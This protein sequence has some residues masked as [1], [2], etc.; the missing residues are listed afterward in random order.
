[1]R[2]DSL[3][4]DVFSAYLMQ[5]P[6]RKIFGF[7]PYVEIYYFGKQ[8]FRPEKVDR[9]I[10]HTQRRYQRRIERHS[11]ND[12]IVNRL[13]EKRERRLSV[14]QTKRQ[15][16]NFWM[17]VVGEQPAIFDR[18]KANESIINIR[19]YLYT[20][21]FFDANVRLRI[22]TISQKGRLLRASYI[23]KEGS[24]YR[25]YDYK[26]ITAQADIDSLLTPQ[27]SRWLPSGSVYDREQLESIRL[28]IEKSLRDSGY[29]RFSR[30]YV[31]V[32][33][34]TNQQKKTAEL[35]FLINEP[36]RIDTSQFNPKTIGKEATSMA[37]LDNIY[38]KHIRYQ[39]AMP[40]F[41]VLEEGK[42][43]DTSLA[44]KSPTYD[45]DTIRIYTAQQRYKP[46]LLSENIHLRRQQWFSESGLRQTQQSLISLDMFKFIN[47]SLED[48]RNGY[49]IPVI[50]VNPIE[51]LSF[52]AEGGLSVVQGLPGPFIS[53]SLK[54]RNPFGGLEIFENSFRFAIDGQTSLS[55][56]RQVFSSTE[57]NFSSSLVIPHFL[58][59]R[60]WQYRFVKRQPKTTFGINFNFINRPEYTRRNI[61][62]FL[63]Y[64]W[65]TI[66]HYRYEVTPIDVNI[67]N[68]DRTP[69]LDDFLERLSSPL[70][71][72][73]F[74]NAFIIS[75]QGSWTYNDI[76]QQNKISRY[77]RFY[78]ESGG[79]VLNLF[80]RAFF[81]DENTF[82]GL[83]YFKYLKFYT[84]LR[85][86]YPLG[87]HNT[88]A[89]R[90]LGGAVW[91]YGTSNTVPYEK[92]F[93]AGG[94]NSL[95]AW[96]PR[97]L[98]PGSYDHIDENGM[99]SYRFEQPGNI[100]LEGSVEYRFK[101]WWIIN[102]ALFV[103]MGN[104]WTLTEDPDRPGAKISTNFWREIAFGTGFGLRFDFTFLLLRLDLGIKAID[105]AMP[106]GQ[107]WVLHNLSLR[108]P[109]SGNNP[110]M[111]NI[112]I[113]Y[114]F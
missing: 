47:I 89:M 71:Q 41:L 27:L 80:D 17:R 21:G 50:V 35:H 60:R 9:Q 44:Y 22:D 28:N 26:L 82:F 62:T 38:G 36:D 67:V 43:A 91:P 93:F 20:K 45:K 57:I 90:F 72:Q 33:V 23:I 34:D 68:T 110:M 56:D 46:L 106:Q 29:Y 25:I 112:G 32:E 64:S 31:V 1:M 13:I 101:L 86:H 8:F 2:T 94:S 4:K 7:M 99:V 37:Y 6:N 109:F 74:Q 53:M 66:P 11:Q 19:E 5:E 42:K 98:G 51:R 12:R 49:L 88:L 102:A 40:Y 107:R 30:E 78:G 14:L 55:D 63:R 75:S 108:Q 100:A 105:P 114:P 96:P 16:G 76:N 61:N 15:E 65:Q 95:R 113:G 103:D 85:Y 70:I 73:S 10:A 24:P 97:R 79:T 104:V 84:D 81:G 83:N 39:L 3:N 58:L 77:V 87:Q 18:N 59:P 92:F 69:A 54:N 48:K 111:L 52:T